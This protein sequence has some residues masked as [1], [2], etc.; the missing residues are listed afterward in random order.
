MAPK[1]QA[2]TSS[3]NNMSW[4]RSMDDALVNAF[5]HE[6]TAGNKVNGQFTTQA[7]D[8]IAS[9]LSVLFAMK[10]DK[11]KIK[12]R[13]KTLKKKFSDVY[14]IF[15][16]GM[17]GFAWNP[18]THLWDA[19]PEVWEALIQSK[20]KA[21]NCRNTSL[22]HYEAMVTLYGNDRAT[23]EEAET[24]SEMRKRLNSTT[25]SDIFDSIDDIDD[26][27]LR[28]E[29]RLEDFDAYN[30]NNDF[31]PEIQ[32]QDPSPT[33]STNNKRKKSKVANNKGKNDDMLGIKGAMQEVAAALREGNVIM[34]ERHSPPISGQEAW[35][36][37]KE[38]GCNENLW[39][40]IFCKLMK[41]VDGLKTVLECP[42]EARK[43]VIMYTVFGSSNP[44]TN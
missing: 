6:F 14:D 42:V 7:H 4:T 44:P 22:P 30:V 31:S 1:K 34:K 36:L 35:K 8:R 33:Q 17:S 29:V 40:M 16:N 23:G 26:G 10:I 11:S 12:N 28:N 15:K 3:G 41:D 27:I 38:C 18:S 37:I 19:E 9:E 5:M 21:A 24:A 2:T 13:W 43:D 39:P 32:S 20:P 25:E